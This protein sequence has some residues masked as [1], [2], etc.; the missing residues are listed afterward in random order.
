MNNEILIAPLDAFRSLNTSLCF[1][2]HS[3][4]HIF[5]LSSSM[6]CK[7]EQFSLHRASRL[8]EI[9]SWLSFNSKDFNFRKFF[10]TNKLEKVEV[11]N[12]KWRE[13]LTIKI[14]QKLYK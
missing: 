13:F 12:K 11:I 8:F 14:N 2:E 10:D 6:G 4:S 9:T 3:S 5:V 1:S 7:N